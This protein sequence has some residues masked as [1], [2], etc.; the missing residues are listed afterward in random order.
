ML[1]LRKKK[2]EAVHILHLSPHRYKTNPLIKKKKD[3]P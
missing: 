1:P 2:I 3:K